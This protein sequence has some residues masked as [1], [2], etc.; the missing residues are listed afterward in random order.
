MATLNL[1]LQYAV[2]G[3]G[4]GAIIAWILF[5]LNLL[6]LR[7]RNKYQERFKMEIN[8]LR[9]LPYGS[10]PFE[11]LAAEIE[12]IMEYQTRRIEEELKS[13]EK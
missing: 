13:I 5:G 1:V 9:K 7:R 8:H 4:V 2:A 10:E 3:L 6:W 11:K 12:D